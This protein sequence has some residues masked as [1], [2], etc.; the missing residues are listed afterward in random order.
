MLLT[1]VPAAAGGADP[2]V[3]VGLEALVVVVGDGGGAEVVLDGGV[4]PPELAVTAGMVLVR[5]EGCEADPPHP[6][7]VIARNVRA[8]I[9]T[10]GGGTD[11]ISQF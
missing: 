6:A 10:A 5:V 2:E 8:N 7:I 9:W 1:V 11:R 3:G 4:G